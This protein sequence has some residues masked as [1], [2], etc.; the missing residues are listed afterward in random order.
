MKITISDTAN[1]ITWA[2]RVSGVLWNAMKPRIQCALTPWNPG[3]NASGA[4]AG[5][6]SGAEV[7]FR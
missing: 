6:T 4:G 5:V 1:L 7:R 3:S 2:G